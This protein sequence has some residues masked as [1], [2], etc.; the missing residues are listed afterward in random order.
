MLIKHQELNF[1]MP[2]RLPALFV[3]IGR[4]IFLIN[5]VAET[6]KASWRQATAQDSDEKILDLDSARQWDLLMDE[7]NSYSLFSPTL[8]LDARYEKKTLEAEGKVF[9]ENYLQNVNKQCLVI[10]RAPQLTQKQLQILTNHPLAMIVQSSYPSKPSILHWIKEQFQKQSIH[11]EAEIISMIE[12]YTRGNLL[13]C[14]QLIE[15]IILIHDPAEALSQDFVK[16]QLYDQ[17]D[18]QLFELSDTCLLGD[19]AQALVILRHALQNRIEPTLILWILT[20]EIRYLIQ[21]IALGKQGIGFQA[22]VTQ[23]KIWPQRAKLYQKAVSQHT[24]AHL[25]SLLL[26]CN[27]L[28]TLIKTSQN[29]QLWRSLELLVLALASG[30]E[31]TPLA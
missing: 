31:V 5:K 4:E 13:A 21:F 26:T 27:T 8:L 6:I 12:L 7:A 24:E 18:Y 15:K 3:L 23:L 25:N 1:K 16:Q 17:S 28:D 2:N 30:K 22:A 10:I 11:I 29:Q 20:Q 14:S 9:F 19:G